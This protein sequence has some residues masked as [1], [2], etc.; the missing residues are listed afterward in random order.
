MAFLCRKYL[1]FKSRQFSSTFR[2]GL[3]VKRPETNIIL[4]KTKRLWEMQRQRITENGKCVWCEML[5]YIILYK[6]DSMRRNGTVASR[7]ITVQTE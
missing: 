2:P 5:F 3:G 6:K 1:I 4:P 7:I